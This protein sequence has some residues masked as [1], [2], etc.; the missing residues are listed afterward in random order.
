MPM[1]TTLRMR[2]PVKPCHAPLRTRS[3]NAAM[4]SSTAC[5]SGTTL[6]VDHDRR[7]ARRAQRHVQHG[8]VLGHVDLVA[9]EHRV[10]ALAQSRLRRP[11]PA[12]GAA[13]RR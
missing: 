10:D 6:A 1:L 9:A 3:A 7:V 12:A 4:R 5:T 2:L 11:A 13:S 8:A